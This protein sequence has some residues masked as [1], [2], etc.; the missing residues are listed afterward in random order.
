MDR[1]SSD[2][3]PTTARV[4]TLAVLS[5]FRNSV[6]RGQVERYLDQVAALRHHLDTV[7]QPGEAWAI[8]VYAVWGDCVDETPRAL[9]R[10]AERRALRMTL[11][12]RSHGGPEFGSTERPERLR[13]LSWV[14]NG[15]LEAIQDEDY[16]LYVESDLVWEP[17]TVRHLLAVLQ[18]TEEHPDD[19]PDGWP[20]PIDVVAPSVVAGAP[21]KR[22]DTGGEYRDVFYDIFVFRKDGDR[23]SPFWP[24]HR[25]VAHDRPTHVDSVGSCL[26]MRGDVARACRVIEDNALLGFCKDAWAKGFGVACDLRVKVRQP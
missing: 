14:A 4:R 15:G 20:A 5:F 11:I 3:Y 17:A 8:R 22:E 16:V 7:R 18:A 21:Y 25:G 9:I 10:G 13:A 19:A 12:E 6:I 2:S 26:V 24:Y 1:T 23:F